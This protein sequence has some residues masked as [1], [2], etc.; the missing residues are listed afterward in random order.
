MSPLSIQPGRGEL[1]RTFKE[2]SRKFLPRGA[3]EEG[4]QVVLFI[5]L[6][7]IWKP[8][9]QTWG[10]QALSSTLPDFSLL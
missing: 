1:L 4:F 10:Q 7:H 2:Y 9:P 5:V 6:S 8:H 3:R